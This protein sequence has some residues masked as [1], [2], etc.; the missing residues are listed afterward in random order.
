MKSPDEQFISQFGKYE[1]YQYAL[2]SQLVKELKAEKEIA[3]ELMYDEI[4]PKMTYTDYELGRCYAVS[5]SVEDMALNIIDVKEGYDRRMARYQDKAEMF[6]IA[7]DSLSERERDVVNVSYFNHDNQL[8]LSEDYFKEVLNEAQA[9][10]CSY[11]GQA[12]VDGLS[13][14]QQRRKEKL[15]E[16]VAEFKG[17]R[18]HVS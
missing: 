15:R 14:A 4:S 1:L 9:K 7:M 18:V 12:R 13:A 6:E 8:G 2:A 10:L 5:T 16:Q 11:I 17:H 3:V